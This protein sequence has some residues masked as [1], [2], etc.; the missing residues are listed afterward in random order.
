[1]IPSLLCGRWAFATWQAQVRV[2]SRLFG[3]QK[4][5]PSKSSLLLLWVVSHSW[6]GCWIAGVQWST[7]STTS[8]ALSLLRTTVF[9]LL[10]LCILVIKQTKMGSSPVHFS[11][12]FLICWFTLFPPQLQGWGYSRQCSLYT[13]VVVMIVLY[14]LE[15]PHPFQTCFNIAKS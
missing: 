15:Y 1:M 9:D 4:S 10:S 14:C 5:M 13:V 2:D 3:A 11:C 7:L 8:G 6:S 12:P